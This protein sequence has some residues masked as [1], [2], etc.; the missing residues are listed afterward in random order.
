MVL[1]YS[2]DFCLPYYMCFISVLWPV[3]TFHPKNSLLVWLLPTFL[4]FISYPFLTPSSYT[5]PPVVSK[6]CLTHARVFALFSYPPGKYF[7]GLPAQ[8]LVGILDLPRQLSVSFFASVHSSPGM[9]LECFQ[10]FR[11]LVSFARPRAL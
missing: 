7:F 1:K 8:N 6:M 2:S 10:N 3:W 5:K 11:N 4:T 9:P